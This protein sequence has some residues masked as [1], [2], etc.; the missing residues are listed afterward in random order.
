MKKKMCVKCRSEFDKTERG[1]IK[2]SLKV[3][4]GEKH[5]W[6]CKECSKKLIKLLEEFVKGGG[7]G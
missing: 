5:V 3:E 1:R 6:F 4:K 2:I 7:R